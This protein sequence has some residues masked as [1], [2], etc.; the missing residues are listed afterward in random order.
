MTDTSPDPI[1]KSVASDTPSRYNVAVPPVASP[2]TTAA[3]A[4]RLVLVAVSLLAR[5]T[6]PIGVSTSDVGA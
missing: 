1:V 3:L 6:P 2:A 5:T 4:V